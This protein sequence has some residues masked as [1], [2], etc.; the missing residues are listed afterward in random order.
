MWARVTRVG[1]E[2]GLLRAGRDWGGV[3]MERGSLETARDQGPEWALEKVKFSNPLRT[4]SPK[5]PFIFPPG[6][7]SCKK[8]TNSLLFLRE[9]VI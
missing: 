2:V 7:N 1:D 3:L 8:S 4:L 5:N 9:N 6:A